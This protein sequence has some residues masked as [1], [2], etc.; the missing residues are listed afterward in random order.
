ML[1]P[2]RMTAPQVDFFWRMKR[3]RRQMHA[4]EP[5]RSIRNVDWQ[6]EQTQM[7]RELISAVIIPFIA[8]ADC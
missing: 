4:C 8:K 6:V 3:V 5:G 2:S 1:W 7:A